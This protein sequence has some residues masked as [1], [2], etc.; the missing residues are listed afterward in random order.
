MIENKIY[1]YEDSV[2]NFDKLMQIL[3]KEYL[4]TSDGKATEK[5]DEIAKR[6]KCQGVSCDTMES[7]RKNKA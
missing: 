6:L 2:K 1:Y 7:Q 4:V 3:M 5:A